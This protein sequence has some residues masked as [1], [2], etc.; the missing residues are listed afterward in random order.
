MMAD[1]CVIASTIKIVFTAV[2]KHYTNNRAICS[3]FQG[4]KGFYKQLLMLHCHDHVGK[5]SEFF[6]QNQLHIQFLRKLPRKTLLLFPKQF[7]SSKKACATK[8]HCGIKIK[9]DKINKKIHP[10][11]PNVSHLIP[12]AIF[13]KLQGVLNVKNEERK[14]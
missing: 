13:R 5:N 3:F 8:P 9:S 11:L 1:Y 2:I 4:E 6:R 7:L 14:G 12:P 10:F